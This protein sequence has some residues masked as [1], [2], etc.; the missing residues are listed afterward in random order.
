MLSRSFLSSGSFQI[1][2]RGSITPLQGAPDCELSVLLA[3]PCSTGSLGVP[4]LQV[5]SFGRACLSLD[6]AQKAPELS[7]SI[8]KALH[9]KTVKER[10][11]KDPDRDAIGFPNY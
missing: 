10:I 4:Q 7:V 6:I 11:Q 9:E 2:T 5:Q 8:F 3:Y 1:Q